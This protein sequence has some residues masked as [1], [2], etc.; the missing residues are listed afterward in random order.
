MPNSSR[1]HVL[2]TNEN[3]TKTAPEF[4]LHRTHV[5]ASAVIHKANSCRASLDFPAKFFE[6]SLVQRHRPHDHTHLRR[7]TCAVFVTETMLFQSV[8][9]VVSSIAAL[10]GSLA[11]GLRRHACFPGTQTVLSGRVAKPEIFMWRKPNVTGTM[12]VSMSWTHV[13]EENERIVSF[14]TQVHEYTIDEVR[15]GVDKIICPLRMHCTGAN[16]HG[17][18]RMSDAI[19]IQ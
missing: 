5:E 6:S 17:C 10:T 18:G 11:V 4:V 8:G 1:V 3:H 14:H 19:Q 16:I 15:L 9:R 13:A 2:S 7:T 12:R